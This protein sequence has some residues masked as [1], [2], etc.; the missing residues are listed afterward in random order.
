MTETTLAIEL[1]YT[2]TLFVL[3]GLGCWKLVDLLLGD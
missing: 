2:L 1:L 3:V